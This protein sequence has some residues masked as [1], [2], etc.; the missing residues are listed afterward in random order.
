M[1]YD[2]DDIDQQAAVVLTELGISQEEAD[3]HTVKAVRFNAFR[4]LRNL[5][6]KHEAHDVSLEAELE[7]IGDDDETPTPEWLSGNETVRKLNAWC[8]LVD[9]PTPVLVAGWK[10]ACGYALS[11]AEYRI[12]ERFRK[13]HGI[14]TSRQRKP[15][16]KIA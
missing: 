12:L 16:L 9:M 6:A 2:Q 14:K 7:R 10:H 13:T 3:P 5:E 1:I 8:V 4:T 15:K 11:R